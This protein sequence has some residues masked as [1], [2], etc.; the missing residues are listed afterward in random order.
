MAPCG[1]FDPIPI[2]ALSPCSRPYIQPY[3]YLH[4]YP[5]LPSPAC[6]ILHELACGS[7]QYHNAVEVLDLGAKPQVQQ[8]GAKAT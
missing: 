3:P 6:N 2:P 1:G 7:A 8:L 4:H 5:P